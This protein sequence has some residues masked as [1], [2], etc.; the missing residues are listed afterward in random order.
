M[1]TL[2]SRG[3]AAAETG[4]TSSPRSGCAPATTR[5][6]RHARSTTLNTPRPPLNTSAWMA[7]SR[8]RRP[9]RSSGVQAACCHLASMAPPRWA[10]STSRSGWRRGCGS[11]PAGQLT[12]AP[13]TR[14]LTEP[15]A[16]R[17]PDLS[18]PHADMAS[19]RSDWGRLI[20]RLGV[21]TGDTPSA[22]AVT[23]VQP[24]SRRCL[25]DSTRTP[26]G[27]QGCRRR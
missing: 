14:G 12:D 5:S 17:V 7:C 18:T 2:G 13:P 11:A 8:S 25:D 16:T 1:P 27:G 19:A 4:P 26:R 9:A 3:H 15:S 10:R 21:G 20:T 23:D 6:T 24:P 22:A